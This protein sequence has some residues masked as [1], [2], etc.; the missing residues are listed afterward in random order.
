MFEGVLSI[1]Y[2]IFGSVN[3]AAGLFSVLQIFVMA[4]AF[5]YCLVTMDEYGVSSKVTLASFLLFF[6]QR[7]KK[8]FTFAPRVSLIR[9]A[10]AELPQAR[11]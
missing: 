9:P 2:W 7:Y 8:S 6:L 3:A 10:P 5:A 11:N 4:V 1:G